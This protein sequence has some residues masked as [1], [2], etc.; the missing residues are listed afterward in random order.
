MC[1]ITL[2]LYTGWLAI[3]HIVYIHVVLVDDFILNAEQLSGVTS[4]MR[5]DPIFKT[6]P[7]FGRLTKEE[8]SVGH[9][10]TVAQAGDTLH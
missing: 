6:R 8:R 2:I 3:V 7:G 5:V 1:G 9:A 4:A 10:G